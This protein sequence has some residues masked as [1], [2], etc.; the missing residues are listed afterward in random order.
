MVDDLGAG[1]DYF[2]FCLDE[3]DL[4]MANTNTP[5]R[6]ARG[7]GRTPAPATISAAAAPTSLATQT[8]RAALMPPPA[9]KQRTAP[10]LPG[11]T[12]PELPGPEAPAA[13]SAPAA[14]MPSATAEHSQARSRTPRP[15]FVRASA[16]IEEDVRS[17][18]AVLSAHRRQTCTAARVALQQKV[19]ELKAV[20]VGSWKEPATDDWKQLKLRAQAF[21]CTWEPKAYQSKEKAV[22]RSLAMYESVAK[23]NSEGEKEYASAKGIADEALTDA[24]ER[25]NE[26]T[27]LDA[28]VDGSSQGRSTVQTQIIAM[29][30]VASGSALSTSTVHAV[31][32]EQVEQLLKK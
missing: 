9:P 25:M 14:A 13:Q 23:K 8:P 17:R 11:P 28:V 27:L 30:D 31:L 1:D 6:T 32:W 10:E 24:R 20:D 19:D 3:A 26:I 15:T 16:K 21:L 4:D 7:R 22:R 12:A 5:W 2:D 29:N 18:E